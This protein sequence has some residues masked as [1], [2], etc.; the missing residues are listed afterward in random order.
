MEYKPEEENFDYLN[1]INS[2]HQYIIPIKFDER[3]C[4]PHDLRLESGMA[5]I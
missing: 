1:C 3:E 4:K 2:N 5:N